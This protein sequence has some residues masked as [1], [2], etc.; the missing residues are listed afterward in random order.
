MVSFDPTLSSL[1]LRRLTHWTIRVFWK[2]CKSATVLH[3]DWRVVPPLRGATG[4][5]K[6]DPG[7]A[8]SDFDYPYRRSTQNGDSVEAA[9]SSQNCPTWCLESALPA[10]AAAGTRS[11]SHAQA[12]KL[13]RR[14]PD[15]FLAL[16]GSILGSLE[17]STAPPR[18]LKIDPIL[19]FMPVLS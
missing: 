4:H 5:S 12:N 15:C 10:F 8:A 14:L 3:C 13:R 17:A 11:H 19:T 9:D 18:H 7:N 16:S 2:V 6:G 1:G